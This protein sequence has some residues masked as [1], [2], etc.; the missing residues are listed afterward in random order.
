MGMKPHTYSG[1]GGML[2]SHISPHQ[3]L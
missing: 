3:F 2:Q 1:N